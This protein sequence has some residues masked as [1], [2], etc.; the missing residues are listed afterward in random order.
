M[1]SRL[2]EVV[3]PAFQPEL[4]YFCIEV[5]NIAQGSLYPRRTPFIARPVWCSMMTLFTLEDSQEN[6]GEPDPSLRIFHNVIHVASRK[7]HSQQKRNDALF[8]FLIF[9]KNELSI[10]V[11]IAPVNLL[12]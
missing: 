1:A 3:I 6:A 11:E 4:L 2:P 7:K 10:T 9:S 8:A 12:S 5:L